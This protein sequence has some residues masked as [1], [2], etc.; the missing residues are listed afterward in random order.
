MNA[1]K[2]YSLI[3]TKLISWELFSDAT[4]GRLDLYYLRENKKQDCKSVNEFFQS[5]YKK[6][7]QTNK[8]VNL[9]KNQQG[10]I[11]KIGSRKSN[12]YSRIYEIKDSLKFEYEM[13]GRFIS[14]FFTLLKTNNLEELENQLSQQFQSYFGKLLPLNFS[15]TDWLVMQ[16]RPIRKQESITSSLKTHYIRN[17]DFKTYKN[18]QQFFTL[19]QFLVY[20]QNLDYEIDS[21]GSTYY[22]R[23]NFQIK[24]F[25]TFTNQSDNYYQLGKLVRFFNDL[26]KNSLIQF[27]SNKRYRSLVTIPEIDLNKGKKNSWI[28]EVWIAEELF[29]YAHPFLF[30]DLLNRKLTKHQFEVQFYVIK[31][32][33]SIDIEKKFIIK[34]FFE[35][36]PSAI[37]NQQKKAMKEYFIQLIQLF[38]DSDLIEPNCKIILDNKLYSTN[39][40][41]T[42]NISEGFVRYEKLTI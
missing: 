4:L 11:L 18:R 24:D 28:A 42:N 9:E 30:P 37:T 40:L 2:F 20:A 25:L 7:K 17:V 16:L 34:E 5:C 6:L 26:Q 1:Q 15:Y 19:L 35:N 38:V 13:K 22:R 27:F 29:S 3:K 33:S 32:Y 8:T 14:K 10:S 41:N 31:V 21:L 12:H 36:Y 39:Q 23:V